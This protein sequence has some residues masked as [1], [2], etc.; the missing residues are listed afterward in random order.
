MKKG[1]RLISFLTVVLLITMMVLPVSATEAGNDVSDAVNQARKGVLQV[2]LVYVDQGSVEH[3]IQGGSG[4]L[5][6]ATNGAEYMITNTHVVTM[7]TDIREAASALFGVDFNNPNSLNMQIQV[8]VKRDVVI[9]ATVVNSSENMDFAIL[10]LEQPIYDRES[11]VIDKN[12][13]HIV[14]TMDV[15]ALGFPNAIELVEDTPFY[16]SA[17]VNI[18]KGIV[19]KKATIDDIKYIRHSATMSDGNSGG[20][21]V[22][23]KG[24]VIGVNTMGVDDTYFYSLQISEV[25]AILDA[26]GI[27][28]RGADLQDNEIATEPTPAEPIPTEIPEILVDKNNLSTELS[29]AHEKLDDQE[30]NYTEDSRKAIEDAIAAGQA[31][32]DNAD[33]S[34]PEVDAAAAALSEA[35]SQMAEVSGPNML[36]ILGI[37]AAFIVIVIIVIAIILVK[38]NKKS[39]PVTVST[40]PPTGKPVVPEAGQRTA[41]QPQPTPQPIPQTPNYANF[42][43]SEGSGETSVLSQGSGETSVLGS[44]AP[45][46]SATLTRKKNGENIQINKQ[47]FKIGKE[48][49]RVDYCIPD[50][51]SISRVHAQ[52]IFKNNTYFIMDMKST[53]YTYV[54]GNKVV[55]EQEMKLKSGD[56]IRL[57]DE[58]FEFKC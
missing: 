1:R 50:N 17:D 39:K 31:V 43:S 9:K 29:L 40:L 20:P 6:G 2:N 4:F 54:N 19:S 46:I 21:L 8:V 22:N 7:N 3:V 30:I 55:P 12:D 26:L 56:K 27:M 52:I 38:G 13:D 41:P 5:I 15:Y 48:R 49:I 51:N 32:L 33:A 57:A 58:E 47:L 34:Q 44:N 10:K 18:T 24:Q 42:G 36:L 11:L 23:S 37:I 16:T 45:Q 35:R 28:Y 53:N 25:T 14:E